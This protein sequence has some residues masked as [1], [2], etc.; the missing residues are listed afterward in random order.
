MRPS[1]PPA[2]VV[3]SKR[4]RLTPRVN[5]LKRK[6]LLDDDMILHAEYVFFSMLVTVFLSLQ[7]YRLYLYLVNYFPNVVIDVSFT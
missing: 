1:P 2:E 7:S 4:P 5:V 6:V 3:S